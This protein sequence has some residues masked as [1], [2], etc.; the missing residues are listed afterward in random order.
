VLTSLNSLPGV[1]AES[2]PGLLQLPRAGGGNS[3]SPET[4]STC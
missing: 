2:K 1:D 3:F 4:S